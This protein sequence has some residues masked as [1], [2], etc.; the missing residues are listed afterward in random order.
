MW[1]ALVPEGEAVDPLQRLP[2]L[3]VALWLPFRV[4]GAV[5]IIPL[6]EELAFRGYLLRRLQSSHFEK[7]PIG[8]LTPFSLVLS[9]LAFGALHEQWLAGTLAGLAY[10]LATRSRAGL[11]DAVVAH[12]VTNLC[13]AVQVLVQGDWWLW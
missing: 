12:G 7:V 11:T 5:L 1:V 3:L 2:D 4:I 10:G 9:S 13:L 8:H 6:T